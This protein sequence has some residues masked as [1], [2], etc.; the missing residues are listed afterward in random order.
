MLHTITISSSKHSRKYPVF[1]IV[2]ITKYSIPEP[3][4]IPTTTKPLSRRIM[5]HKPARGLTTT[6]RDDIFIV[7]AAVL[8][9]LGL[10]TAACCT[11]WHARRERR[12]QHRETADAQRRV[13]RGERRAR[14][15]RLEKKSLFA[16]ECS[17]TEAGLVERL[18][19]EDERGRGGVDEEA[20][21]A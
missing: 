12:R 6:Q 3:F 21:R 11:V 9:F 19:R 16:P 8:V 15:A 4:L 5:T 2:A 7:L 20:G 18:S 10:S 1:L 13:R 17:T 14:R